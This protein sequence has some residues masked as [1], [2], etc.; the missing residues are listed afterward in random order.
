MIIISLVLALSFTF[1]I[2]SLARFPNRIAFFLGSYLVFISHILFS[3]LVANAFHVLN[4][5]WIILI[6]QA[7]LVVAGLFVWRRN[8]H[9]SM[10]YLFL[11]KWDIY[12]WFSKI[13]KHFPVFLLGLGII[14]AF[15]IAAL[16]I[17]IVPPNNND[18]LTTHLSRIGYWLQH[19][20][21]FPWPTFWLSQI[22]Y[23]INVS[24]QVFWTIL[25]EGT[26]RLAGFVQ[27]VSGIVTMISIFGIARLLKYSRTQSAFAALIWGSF[28][29]ILMQS[30]TTQL[31]L[32]ATGIFLP[33]IYFLILGIR[34]ENTTAFIYSGLSVALAIGAKQTVW[35]MMPGLV[36][37]AIISVGYWKK[38]LKHLLMWF[39]STAVFFVLLSAYFFI[40][41]FVY[42][43]TPFGPSE[44][45][46]AGFV[47]YPAYQKLVYN[48]PR[49]AYQAIDFSGLPTREQRW[50][51]RAREKLVGGLFNLI[52]FPIEAPVAVQV[53]HTFKLDYQPVTTEDESWFGVL[54]VLLL[55]PSALLEFIDGLRKKDHIRI[56]L[57][58]LSL[59][60]LPLIIVVRGGWDPYQ[61]RYF[62]AAAGVIAPF[63]ARWV[64]EK[65]VYRIG[66]WASVIIGLVVIFN[67]I[68]Y[69]P[70]KPLISDRVDIFTA[71]RQVLQGVQT[72][73]MKPYMKMVYELPE[74]TVIGYYSP[75]YFWDYP[76]FGEHFT[77]RVIPITSVELLSDASQLESLGIEYIIVSPKEGQAV[78]VSSMFEELSRQADKWILYKLKN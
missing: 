54:G 42:F 4:N 59:S 36:L 29:I 53:G 26:D 56:G 9:P 12:R 3:L 28:P 64:Q 7:A 27:W 77:R 5:R 76:L 24:L 10:R 17:F 2:V 41:N 72:T 66:V 31:D 78:N 11:P 14:T 37:F 68:V 15:L 69:N 73:Y 60:F 50:G 13:K 23:P 32:A 21:F 47:S 1:F 55:F 49:F 70:A 39:G 30:T 6:I 62:I 35:F 67:I 16:L 51:V 38:H 52:N 40:V 19:G 46:S 74:K 44:V 48:I 34:A 43:K 45:V 25:F 58:L 57:F 18:S 71:N 75:G 8:G 63:M 65:I 20:S 33:A 61:G 22:Y